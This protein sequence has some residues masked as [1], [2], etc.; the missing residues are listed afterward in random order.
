MDKAHRVKEMLSW[1]LKDY[2]R[3]AASVEVVPIEGVTEKLHAV[4]V[5][6]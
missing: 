3:R 4:P 2:F 1:G 5:T 6:N